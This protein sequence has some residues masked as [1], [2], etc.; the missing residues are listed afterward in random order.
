MTTG[1]VVP[2]AFGAFALGLPDFRRLTFLR[3]GPAQHLQR[4]VILIYN[5]IIE[6][7]LLYYLMLE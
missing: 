2:V 4:S 7:I 6:W 3:H 5:I 1:A